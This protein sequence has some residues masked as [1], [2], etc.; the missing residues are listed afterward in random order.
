[1][2]TIIGIMGPGKTSCEVLTTAFELG[3]AMANNHWVLLTGGRKVGV[4]HEALRGAKEADGLTMGILPDRDAHNLSEY[5]DLPV[6]T[7]MGGARNVINILTSNV[8]VACGV[9]LGTTSEVALALK[10]GKPVIL[11]QQ[12]REAMDFFESFHQPNL[13]MAKSV[14]DVIA[15]IKKYI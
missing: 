14:D 6:I 13:H 15:L 1:M 4:M 10:E 7:G 3:K 12:T 9:G 11:V 5:V 2:K 8:V